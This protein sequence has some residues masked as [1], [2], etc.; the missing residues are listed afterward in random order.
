MSRRLVGT[1]AFAGYVALHL[2]L[3]LLV[4]WSFNASRSGARWD[5]FTLHWY[6]LLLQRG[7][8]WIALRTSLVVGVVAT[9]AST[10][11][12]TFAALAMHRGP[13]RAATA[14]E[15]SLV[16]PIVT[17]EIVAGISLLILFGAMGIRLGLVTVIVAHITFCLPFTM[18]VVLARLRG[19][20]RTLEDAAL[21][22]GADELTAFRR[23]TV[24]LL[25]PGIVAA[26]LLAFTL[27]FDDFIIT[28][29]TA[30]AGTTTLPLVIY[31]MVRRTVEPTVNA[32]SALLVVG[33]TVLLLIAQR[34]LA[35]PPSHASPRAAAP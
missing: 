18:L 9:V 5:G 22:L 24:P 31:G 29:F 14:I 11:L 34:W 35:S 3:L 17:P 30:G 12:G 2:P 13:Q 4:I 19:M 28:F 16:V 7:D 26:A 21:T 1:I 8:L 10:V 32:L 25:M 33:T 27:S 15:A 20:D 23:I 6:Q